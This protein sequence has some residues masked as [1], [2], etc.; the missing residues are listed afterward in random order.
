MFKALFDY[1][2]WANREIYSAVS[3]IDAERHPRERHIAIR[4]LNHIYVTDDIF[5][6]H[7]SGHTHHYTATNTE[8]TPALETL[9]TQVAAL[10]HWYLDY[11]TSADAATLNQPIQFQFTDGQAGCMTPQEMLFHI[12]MH[13]GYHRGA[14]GRIL[15]ELGIQPPADTL[16]GF[17]H[18]TQ[19]QRREK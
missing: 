12:L 5:K 13:G 17:W 15:A 10:D 14:V 1:K 6:A 3:Q 16:A 9:Q 4:L 11:V 19:P 8:E 2:I 7:L 18:Q